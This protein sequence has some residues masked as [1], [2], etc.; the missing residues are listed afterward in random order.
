M[1]SK[2]FGWLT[3]NKDTKSSVLSGIVVDNNDPEKL[4][5]LKIR[6][7]EIY[8]T[9]N[10]ILDIDLPWINS[11]PSSII[12]NS[13]TTSVF[14]VPEIG[15]KVLVEFPTS[16]PYFGFYKGGYNSVDVRNDF[17]DEDYPNTYGFKDSQNN[18]FKINKIKNITE[19]GHNSGN[20]FT[21]NE[22]TSI[23]IFH[24][25][26]TIATINQDGSVS[27]LVVGNLDGTIQGNCNLNVQGNCTVTVDV[28]ANLI[29]P[30]VNVTST[31]VNVDAATTNLGVGGQPIA[32]LN[33]KV[34][35]T[36]TGG[37][38]AGVHL[39]RIIEGGVNTSI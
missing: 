33:D 8:G 35:V 23:D 15:T 9:E 29:S 18:Y 34:E 28:M 5:R 3:E 13:N 37:S 24:H 10:E 11:I 32:R 7:L 21:I 1:L 39:G 12:G 17:F 4:G 26:G 14:G 36:V 16:N 20:K 19:L 31:T 30:L 22:D 27:F 38:S 25:T 2:P 6:I